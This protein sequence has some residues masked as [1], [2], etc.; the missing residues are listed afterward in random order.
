M[1]DLFKDKIKYELFSQIQKDLINLPPNPEEDQINDLIQKIP[2]D[3]LNS[4]DDLKTIIQLF[5]SYAKNI[6]IFHKRNAIKLLE[7]IMPQIKTHLQNESEFFC[8]TFEHILYIKL[9]MH[10]E[11]LISINSIIKEINFDKTGKNLE[12]FYPEIIEKEPKAYLKEYKFRLSKIYSD[13]EITEFKEKRRK[14]FQWLRESG[15]FHDP[16]Y[17]EIEPDQLRLSIKLDDIEKFQ[18]IISNSNISI[19]SKLSENIFEC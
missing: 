2:S 1:E 6:L 16:L 14:H 13:E 11:G 18:T 8:S 9:W 19:N 10:Q 17:T 15:D 7:K 12:Y 5:S 3:S 4:K